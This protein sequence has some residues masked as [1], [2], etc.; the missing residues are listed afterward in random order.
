MGLIKIRAQVNSPEASSNIKVRRR[1]L[2]SP[3]SHD[4]QRTCDYV[5]QWKHLQEKR[6]TTVSV[7]FVNFNGK[8]VPGAEE[9]SIDKGLNTQLGISWVDR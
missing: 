2:T 6:G 5:E 3:T 8:P 4:V 1:H 7:L 9:A